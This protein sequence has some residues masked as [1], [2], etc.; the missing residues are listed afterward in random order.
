MKAKI[1]SAKNSS[2]WYASKIGEVV[3]IE[4]ETY[5]FYW[6]REDAGYINII[7]KDDVEF[8]DNERNSNERNSNAS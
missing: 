5:D 8:V 7:Y 6:A 3:E 4:K 1:T 2:L